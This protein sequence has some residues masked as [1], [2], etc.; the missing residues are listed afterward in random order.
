MPGV[1][2]HNMDQLTSQSVKIKK[3]NKW[4]TENDSVMFEELI[5][6]LLCVYERVHKCIISL[7]MDFQSQAFHKL[8]SH[9]LFY[10]VKWMHMSRH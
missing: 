3:L 6:V 1:E 10:L 5:D 2:E 8:P 9:E 4:K 7:I